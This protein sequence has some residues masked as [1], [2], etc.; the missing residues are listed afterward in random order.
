MKGGTNVRTLA[1]KVVVIT[2]ASSG[3]GELLAYRVAENG[4]TPVLLARSIERL[5]KITGLI[6]EKTNGSVYYYQLDVSSPEHVRV[7]FREIYE[8]LGFV[9]VL[10]NNAGFGVFKELQHADLEQIQ[11]MF[12]VNVIG[13]ISCTKQVL[14]EMI[15]ENKGHII[16]ISSQSG[17]MGTPKSSVYSA[18]KHAVL[19]FTNSLRLELQNQNIQVSSVNPGPIK[20]RFFEIAD[21]TGNYVKNVEKYML[22][23]AVVADKIIQL[24]YHPK[25]EINLPRWMNTGSVLYNLFPAI[26]EKVAGRYFSMK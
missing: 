13:L 17:K 21:E 23:P 1:G 6:K 8:R 7:V 19:G 20:T 18:T 2:G 9:D 16:N 3:I 26:I 25:R 15:K 11:S 12:D 14:P 10:V 5:V 4:G 22:D 24:M